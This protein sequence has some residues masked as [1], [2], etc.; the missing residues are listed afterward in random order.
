MT[1]VYILKL[2][3]AC[4]YVGTTSFSIANCM[5]NHMSG[6]GGEWT[7]L[8][9]PLVLVKQMEYPSSTNPRLQ[10][11]LQVKQLM[12][13]HG[14]EKVRGGSYSSV[15]LTR[16]QTRSLKREIWYADYCC[17]RCGNRRH[18]TEDCSAERDTTGYLIDSHHNVSRQEGVCEGWYQSNINGSVDVEK[19]RIAATYNET[20]TRGS[21]M[22]NFDSI[23]LALLE[24]NDV[25]RRIKDCVRATRSLIEVTRK[26][27]SNG[28]YT[29][30]KVAFEHGNKEVIETQTNASF[31]VTSSPD[32]VVTTTSSKSCLEQEDIVD[33]LAP[34]ERENNEG[35]NEHDGHESGIHSDTS[36]LDTIDITDSAIQGERHEAR[37]M[38]CSRCGR[39]SHHRSRCYELMD[40]HGF[41]L[42]DCF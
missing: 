2:T 8:H 1:L 19:G 37:Q 3:D 21:L 32:T 29:P 33:E 38:P 6:H 42:S 11:D 7:K 18:L 14:I 13:D 41:I 35:R 12:L 9:K 28:T 40:V 25:E 36:S 26:K 23:A 31:G 4:F 5:K 39:Y 17:C 20:S 22:S 10:Q 34:I 16:G 30:K 27:S 15:E 24:S